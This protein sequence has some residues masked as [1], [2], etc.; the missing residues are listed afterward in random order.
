MY[1]IKHKTED[2]FIG[3]D[4]ASG[5]YPYVSSFPELFITAEKASEYLSS[6]KNDKGFNY[7]DYQVVELKYIPVQIS[8]TDGRYDF[9]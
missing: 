3:V 5:G 4:K 7:K 9:Y 1:A 2:K 8:V 6:C